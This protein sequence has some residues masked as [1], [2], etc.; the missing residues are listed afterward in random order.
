MTDPHDP[1]LQAVDDAARAAARGA[2]AGT[3]GSPS[4]STD[5]CGASPSCARVA[6]DTQGSACALHSSRRYAGQ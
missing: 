5:A 6:A 4:C 3:S 1:D 2:R